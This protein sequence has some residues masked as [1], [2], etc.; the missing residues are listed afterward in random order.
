MFAAFQ[1]A[2]AYH[3]KA[4]QGYKLRKLP[5]TFIIIDSFR[6]PEGFGVHLNAGQSAFRFQVTVYVYSVPSLSGSK[7]FCS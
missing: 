3:R 7:G 4:L 1:G 2:D 6:D 5:D